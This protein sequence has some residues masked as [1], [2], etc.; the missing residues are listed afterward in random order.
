MK[1]GKAAYEPTSL[2]HSTD[3]VPYLPIAYEHIPMKGAFFEAQ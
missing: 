2:P 1:A 3:I